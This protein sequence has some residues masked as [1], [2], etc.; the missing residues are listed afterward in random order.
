MDKNTPV[1]A[2]P[3]TRVYERV[4]AIVKKE[5]ERFSSDV[6]R[7]ATDPILGGELESSRKNELLRRSITLPIKWHRNIIERI[8]CFHAGYELLKSSSGR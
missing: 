4:K 7:R 6:I 2:N 1:Y 8:N 5:R 3:Q